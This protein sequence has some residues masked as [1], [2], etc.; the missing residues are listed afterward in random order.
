MR[1]PDELARRRH[2]LRRLLE[3][4]GITDVRVLD[5]IERTPRELF[6]PRESQALA[7]RDQSLAIAGGQTISQ[8][9]MVARMSELLRLTGGS[10]ERVLEIGTG[11]GYQTCVLAQLASQVVTIERLEEF[12]EPAR[13]I[14]TQLHLTNVEF[15]AGDG[16]LGWSAGAPYDAIIVTAAAPRVP[17]TLYEQLKP[18]GR[19]VIPVGDEQNQVLQI[20]EK[21]PAGPLTTTDCHCRFVPLIGE[22]GWRE[23]PLRK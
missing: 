6:V 15:H 3:K 11:S 18:G 16:T 21:G 13:R 17:E 22:A 12:L 20:V 23:N 9:Y 19:L 4:R 8:P 14:L 10:D 2:E 1:D 5:A 7:Y